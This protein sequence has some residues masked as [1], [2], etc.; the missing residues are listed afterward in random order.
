MSG[1]IEG[2]TIVSV[3]GTD[4]GREFNSIMNVM[5]GDQPCNHTGLQS[6]YVIGYR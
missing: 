3:I 4:I 6:D 2:N 5:I 1:P